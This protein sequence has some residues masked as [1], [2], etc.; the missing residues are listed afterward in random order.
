VLVTVRVRDVPPVDERDACAAGAAAAAEHRERLPL[1]LLVAAAVLGGR[2]LHVRGELVGRLPAVMLL[3][4][5]E[6]VVDLCAEVL[7][8]VDGFALLP[9]PVGVG[10]AAGE[11]LEVRLD[12]GGLVRA[13]GVPAPLTRVGY[14]RGSAINGTLDRVVGIDAH[15]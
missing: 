1:M 4:L 12:R 10:V 3:E 13:G 11:I 9:E 15:R 2:A 6:Q 14:L 7:A 8:A 5:V